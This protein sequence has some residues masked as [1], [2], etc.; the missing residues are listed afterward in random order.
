MLIVPK[1]FLE[2]RKVL[3]RIRNPGFLTFLIMKKASKASGIA[4]IICRYAGI[5]VSGIKLNL[6]G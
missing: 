5:W 3:I 1:Y 4:F 2:K 6:A